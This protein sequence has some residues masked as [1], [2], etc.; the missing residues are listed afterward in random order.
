MPQLDLE[1]IASALRKLEGW[2]FDGGMLVKEWTFADFREAMAFLNAV[3][4]LAETAEHHPDITVNYNRVRLALA[5]HSEGGVTEKD[6]AMAQQIETSGIGAKERRNT[7]RRESD[8]RA[9]DRRQDE[10]R[11]TSRRAGSRRK[12]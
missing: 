2:H 9:G 1:Q 12:A 6:A 3:A 8:R 5:T 7:D 10:R 4:E 11:A